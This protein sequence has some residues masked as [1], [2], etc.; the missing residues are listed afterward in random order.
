MV[1]SQ[2]MAAVDFIALRPL[3]EN[4]GVAEYRLTVGDCHLLD[5]VR[6]SA[7]NFNETRLADYDPVDNRCRFDFVAAGAG[8]DAPAA[9]L[10]DKVGNLEAVGETFSFETLSPSLGRPTIEIV[11]VDGDQFLRISVEASDDVD[12]SYVSFSATGLLASTLRSVGGVIDRAREQAFADSG[13]QALDTRRV[14]Q[15][16][17]SP[18]VVVQPRP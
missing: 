1:A 16:L 6:I 15:C 7:G 11:S 14:E 2:A 5:E 12:L 9:T 10:V 3:I 8:F 13:G 17:R 4:T 18:V